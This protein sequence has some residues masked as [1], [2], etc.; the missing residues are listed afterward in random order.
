MSVEKAS[1][2]VRKLRHR[3]INVQSAT[4]SVCSGTPQDGGDISTNMGS[5][6]E[7]SEHG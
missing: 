4:R 5:G 6:Y 2:I 7:H 3:Q 1:W